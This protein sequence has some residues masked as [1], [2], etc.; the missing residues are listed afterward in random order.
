MNKT[1]IGK[2]TA[3]KGFPPP[4]LLLSGL[5]LALSAFLFLYFSLIINKAHLNIS[6]TPR[7]IGEIKTEAGDPKGSEGETLFSRTGRVIALEK[8]TLYLQTTYTQDN[9]IM[10]AVFKAKI[11]AGATLVKRDI[12]ELLKMGPLADETTGVTPISFKEIKIGDTVTIISSDNIKNKSEFSVQRV[13]KRY[14]S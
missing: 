10:E 2:K 12:N 7:I 13:E 4:L 3:A 6:L 11:S 1:P 14:S 5:I 8:D 9:K